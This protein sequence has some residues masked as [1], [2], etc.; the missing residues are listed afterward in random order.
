MAKSENA[1]AMF[2]P[3]N[4]PAH[5]RGF[6][7][8]ESNIQERQTVPTL[9]YGGKVWSIILNGEKKALTKKNEEGDDIPLPIVR[10]VVIA[11]AP[12]RGRAYY[13]KNYNP[14]TVSAPDCWSDDGIK[15]HD[16]VR[17][18]Q[19]AEC[20][21]CPMSVKGSKV[22]DNNKEV[23][24]C[25]QHRLLAVVPAHDLDFQPMRLKISITSDWDKDNKAQADKG[26]YG[27]SNY[28]DMLRA[29]GVKHTGALI[30]KMKF[31][32]A[33]DYPKVMFGAAGWLDE[34]GLAKVAALAKDPEVLKLLSSSYTPGGTDTPA[35]APA[36]QEAS[37]S[38]EDDDAPVVAARPAAKGKAAVVDEDE[39]EPDVTM[40]PAK[41]PKAAAKPAPAPEPDEDEEDEDD[42]AAKAAAAK[43]A[44]KQAKVQAE[45]AAKAAA[46][47]A[48]AVDEDE[49][50]EPAPPASKPP[51]AAA[52][53]APKGTAAVKPTAAPKEVAAAIGDWDNDD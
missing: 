10:M 5:V 2:N 53:K 11:F 4:M 7:D 15:P 47:K 6:L 29:Q 9:T 21:K 37:D 33:V 20:A 46:A 48:A 3:A 52:S 12:R 39:D 25:Q 35:A 16:T 14:D 24:A 31:D 18:K 40:A 41:A 19:A 1:L 13:E 36:V 17:A 28:T 8:S 50:D 45:A 23:A 22:T 42:A 38:D 49:D 32:G 30:T 44:K 27:F 34:D 43:A 51:K 26:W